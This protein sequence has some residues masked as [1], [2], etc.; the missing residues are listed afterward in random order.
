M[1]NSSR[2]EQI[3]KLL[4]SQSED[5]FLHYAL[6]I[7]YVGASNDSKA[8]EI[9]EQVMNKFPKYHPTYYHYAKLLERQDEI[10]KAIEIY[11]EGMAVCKELGEQHSLRELRAAY[12]E[13][14]YD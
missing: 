11:E 14:L 8:K 6:G 5:P 13:L 3:Q 2:I 1:A 10:D 7:E 4:E 9:F 12:D